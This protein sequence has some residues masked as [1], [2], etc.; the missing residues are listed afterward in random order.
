[1]IYDQTKIT[2]QTIIKQFKVQH[3]VTDNQVTY[4][5]LNLTNKRGQIEMDVHR[6][7]TTRDVAINNTSCHLKE[8]KLVAFKNR[9]DRLL[10]L[11]LN[12]NSNAA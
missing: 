9:V 1:M 7:P 5:D 10:M 11:P 3:K 2:P 12:E 8:H 4:L 6:K